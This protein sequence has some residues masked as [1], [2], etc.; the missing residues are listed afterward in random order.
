MTVKTRKYT[1]KHDFPFVEVCGIGSFLF[2]L[3][4]SI[5]GYIEEKGIEWLI[6]IFAAIVGLGFTYWL[7]NTRNQKLT[8][9]IEHIRI[10]P[11]LSFKPI[12]LSLNEIQGYKLKETYTR[13]GLEYHIQLITKTG[14]NYEIIK[15]A[16][17]DYGRLPVYL[18]NCG[19][20]YLGTKEITWKYK[21]LYS[22]IGIYASMTA[23]I[24]FLLVQVMKI[25]N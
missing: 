12:I 24:L 1:L 18:K 17:S 16:Y 15:D 14:K 11:W 6:L 4:F 7:T 5:K 21:H 23:V 3:G 13:T 20:K 2:I 25:I 22:R 8:F 9:E 19:I 10:R